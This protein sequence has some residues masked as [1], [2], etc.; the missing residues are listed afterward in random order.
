MFNIDIPVYYNSNIKR[1]KIMTSKN[2]CKK[3][4]SLQVGD[5]IDVSMAIEYI[6]HKTAEGKSILDTEDYDTQYEIRYFYP[7]KKGTL[8]LDFTAPNG[9][10]SDFDDDL[11]KYIKTRI[12]FFKDHNLEEYKTPTKIFKYQNTIFLTQRENECFGYRSQWST[13]K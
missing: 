3:E 8:F 5:V 7:R 12:S 4:S 1:R 10:I 13:R 6:V 9:G 2:E 11:N